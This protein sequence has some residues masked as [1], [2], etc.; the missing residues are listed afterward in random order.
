MRYEIHYFHVFILPPRSYLGL[1]RAREHQREAKGVRQKEEREE[2]ERNSLLKD[3][4][5]GKE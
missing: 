2:G 1:Y 3:D 4:S 5:Q